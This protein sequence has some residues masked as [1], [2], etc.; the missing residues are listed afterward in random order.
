MGVAEKG[1]FGFYTSHGYQ[2]NKYLFV[3][4]GAGLNFNLPRDPNMQLEANFPQ[5]IKDSRVAA[6]N[7]HFKPVDSLTYMYGADTMFMTLPIFLDIRGYL[8]IET[9][10]IT[11][12]AML[13]V[14]YSFN[15]SDGFGGMGLFLNPAIGATYKITPRIGLNFSVGYTRQSLGSIKDGYTKDGK[16]LGDLPKYGFYYKDAAGQTLHNTTTHGINFQLGI[17]F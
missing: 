11:P 5:Y 1:S 9:L 6:V 14:G 2:L 15:I 12:Y 8:P 10:L 17:E 13:R 16:V 7:G 3:G 4:L